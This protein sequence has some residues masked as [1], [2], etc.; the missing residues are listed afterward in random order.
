VT[1]QQI[2]DDLFQAAFLALP[3]EARDRAFRAAG[4]I[5]DEADTTDDEEHAA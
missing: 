4:L 2:L 5:G 1:Q 3:W